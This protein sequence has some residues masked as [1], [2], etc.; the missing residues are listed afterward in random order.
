[1][2]LNRA[3]WLYLILLIA[4]GALR[5][6]VLPGLATPLLIVRD[7]IAAFMIFQAF[8]LN[9]LPTTPVFFL[10][11]FIAIISVFAAVLIGHGSLNLS[12]IHI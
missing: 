12:L 1:M 5:K 11:Y 7:P 6:W 4:E 3:I 8:R 2:G 10:S 9:I